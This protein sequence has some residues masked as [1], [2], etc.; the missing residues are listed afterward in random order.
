LAFLAMVAAVPA[1]A[2]SPA[3]AGD[4]DNAWGVSAK[5]YGLAEYFSVD[6]YP[7]LLASAQNTATEKADGEPPAQTTLSDPSIKYTVSDKPYVVLKR[8]PI[9]IVVVDNSEVN[10][11]VV[12]P[13]HKAGYNGI[14]SL[15]YEKQARNLFKSN[16]GGLNFEYIFDGS[17]QAEDIFFEPRKAPMQLRV[18]NDTTAELCQAATPYWGVESATR[19]ELLEDGTIEMTFE[20]IPH[21]ATWKNDYLGFFWASYIHRTESL[22][23]H[24][25]GPKDGGGT[26]WVR[27]ITPA[28]GVKAT[29]RAVDDSREFAADPAFPLTLAFNFS[30]H[31]FTEPW[32]LGEA[33]GMAYVLM[34][35]PQ[36]QIRFTQSPK[37]GGSGN[38][39]WDF[40]WFISQPKV[41]QRYQ[42]AMRVLYTPLPEG[43]PAAARKQV[44]QEIGKIMP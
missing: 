23:I 21:R 6:A 27:G 26:E 37:G 20:C 17:A 2:Q 15:T 5:R 38:P 25:I 41:G 32:Y 18:I 42:M 44:R 43:D 12:L 3:I 35:R 30:D 4:R 24:F 34:F 36:D 9:Q 10:D 8:G 39:A 11:P 19:Y 16:Y 28:H 13:V 40:Q 7:G 22:D 31:R 14:G 1:G 29:H 33:R